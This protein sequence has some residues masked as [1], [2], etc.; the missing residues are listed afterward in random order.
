M[1]TNR[2]QLIAVII[3]HLETV[4]VAL[5][6]LGLPIG[7]GNNRTFLKDRGVCAQSH[8][9][10]QIAIAL[11]NVDLRIH[12]VNNRIR[13]LGIHFRRGSSSQAQQVTRGLDH[14]A[15]Q[16]QAQS[17]GRDLVLA[18]PTQRTQLAF[19]ASD[20]KTAGDDDRINATQSLLRALGG[21]TGIGGN[22]TQVNASVIRKATVLHGLGNRKVSIVQVNVL[23]NQRNLNAVLRRFNA[24][25]QLVPLAPVHV[26]ESQA[27]TLNKEG[28]QALAMQ[29]RGNLID[30][31]RILTFD[32]SIPVDVAHECNLALDSLGQRAIRTQYQRIGLNTDRAQRGHRV[33]GRLGLEL[34]GSGKE[35]DQCDVHKGNIVAAQVGAHLTRSLQEGL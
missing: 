12:G 21:F 5:R 27:K 26:A 11:N 35:G 20:T 7:L 4:T 33:L 29:R 2:F 28:I 10:A 6:N 14:H 31:G 24:L 25:K 22:P 15:L 1:Q 18:C 9:S 23:T 30:R 13:R 19:N 34:T 3:V 16:A 32:D 17:Q 8:G